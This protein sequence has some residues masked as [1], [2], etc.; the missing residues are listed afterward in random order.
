[1]PVGKCRDTQMRAKDKEAMEALNY[2]SFVTE[3]VQ[4]S[5]TTLETLLRAESAGVFVHVYEM[6]MWVLR[7]L[8]IEI[9]K[10]S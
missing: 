7:I 5:Q 10:D 1:M 8:Y 2:S 3:R 9:E 6:Y 4:T